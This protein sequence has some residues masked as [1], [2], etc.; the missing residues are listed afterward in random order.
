MTNVKI[1]KYGKL[2]DPFAAKDSL[3]DNAV[4]MLVVVLPLSNNTSTSSKTL[5]HC[6]LLQKYKFI[7]AQLIALK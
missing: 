6:N 7:S 5:M 1:I 4:E 2:K 3:S